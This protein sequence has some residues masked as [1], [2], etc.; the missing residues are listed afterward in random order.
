MNQSATLPPLMV[1]GNN[2]DVKEGLKWV[3]GA[4]LIGA[5]ASNVVFA[6]R[7]QSVLRQGVR[8]HAARERE[9]LRAKRNLLL[10]R[11][12]MVWARHEQ[13]LKLRMAQARL[14]NAVIRAGD[15]QIFKDQLKE[16]KTLDDLRKS[17]REARE[18]EMSARD[19]LDRPVPSP[20]YIKAIGDLGIQQEDASEEEL[21]TAY[22]MQ[23]TAL[24]ICGHST[25]ENSIDGTKQEEQERIH[26]AYE[27]AMTESQKP[28]EGLD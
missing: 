1:N 19:L 15:A 11:E 5:V 10:N 25:D 17:L 16:L 12:E 22:R 23:L 3:L 9:D 28:K 2:D 20:S 18:R 6:K 27:I 13:K 21:R 14:Q 24:E 8:R 26:K 7:Y 4:C